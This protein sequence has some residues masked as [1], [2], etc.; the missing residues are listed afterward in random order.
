MPSP[1][2]LQS[3]HVLPAA[4]SE[5]ESARPGEVPLRRGEVQVWLASLVA[6][7]AEVASATRIL[8]G[9]ERA[10]ADRFRFEC[11]RRRWIVGRAHWRRLVGAHLECPPE[12][13][14]FAVEARGKPWVSGPA[15][16]HGLGLSLSHSG[17]TALFAVALDSRVG[18]DVEAARPRI[19]VQELSA[20]VLTER[21]RARLYGLSGDR[22]VCEF[23]RCWTR[24][25]A[26]IKAL[27]EGLARDLQSFEVLAV[28]DPEGGAGPTDAEH[29]WW[30]Q[31]LTPSR[32]AVGCVAAEGARFEVRLLAMSRHRSG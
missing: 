1:P 8:S 7:D 29:G 16:H 13:V 3:L 28:S 30:L 4:T 12:A 24:K 20:R 14:E 31:D 9:D 25:E 6:S 27:G 18:V 17:D 5:W 10:R 19:G 32:S 15:G 21:E 2:P 23:L 22:L 26:W 11:H